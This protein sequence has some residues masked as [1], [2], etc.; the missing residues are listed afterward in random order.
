MTSVIKVD[1]I[2]NS[3]G[4]TPTAADLGIS[5]TEGIKNADVWRLY[6]G[7][8]VSGA[9][10]ITQYWEQADDATSGTVG[11]GMTESSGIFTFP[12]TGVWLIYAQLWFEIAQGEDR[13]GHAFYMSTDSGS[14]WDK[15][16][17]AYQS[18]PNNGYKL[19]SNSLALATVSSTTTDRF[20]IQ[21]YVSN[22][23]ATLNG[24]SENNS[25]YV[26]F[27]KIA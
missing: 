23:T 11:T 1:T 21:H 18:S 20:K 16:S 13:V 6:Q 19:T 26:L 24:A 5:V 7:K 2:Q 12:A 8:S 17:Q 22:G 9:G 27:V 25:S 15:I 14:N 10:D 3:S 4:G